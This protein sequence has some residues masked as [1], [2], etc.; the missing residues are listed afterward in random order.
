MWPRQAIV[1]SR[2]TKSPTVSLNCTLP[3]NILK[4]SYIKYLTKRQAIFSQSLFFPY[5]SEPPVCKI[6]LPVLQPRYHRHQ[7]TALEPH[8]LFV[9]PQGIVPVS[10]RIV[11]LQGVEKHHLRVSQGTAIVDNGKQG[12]QGNGAQ[13]FDGNRVHIVDPQSG[14]ESFSKLHSFSNM[15]LQHLNEP[16]KNPGRGFIN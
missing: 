8:R 2:S 16:V 13:G 14:C 15:R 1:S 4:K 3:F 11:A 12:T 10:Y 7:V 5:L 6:S 9:D